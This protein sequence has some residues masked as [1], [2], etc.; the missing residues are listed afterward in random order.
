MSLLKAQLSLVVVSSRHKEEE[1]EE[2]EGEKRKRSPV[3]TGLHKCH[4]EPEFVQSWHELEDADV[5]KI[6][7][8]NKQTDTHMT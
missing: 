1:E 8:A 6:K 4:S 7:Q 5:N 3:A 2:K